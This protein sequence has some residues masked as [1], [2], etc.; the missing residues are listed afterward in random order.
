MPIGYGLRSA[1]VCDGW[2]ESGRDSRGAGRLRR[3]PTRR[4][5]GLRRGRDG[6]ST[7]G[8]HGDGAQRRAT[9]FRADRADGRGSGGHWGDG[10]VRGGQA[11]EDGEVDRDASREANCEANRDGEDADRRNAVTHRHHPV[12]GHHP[13]RHL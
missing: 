10:D 13:V 2:T 11:D 7:D 6:V 1:E 3:R 9:R 8:H 12:T 5:V 4:A